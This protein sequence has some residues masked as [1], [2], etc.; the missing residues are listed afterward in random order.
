MSL[1]LIAT[2]LVSAALLLCVQFSYGQDQLIELEQA[3]NQLKKEHNVTFSYN[4]R[5][6]KGLKLRASL[7]YSDLTG[8][9]SKLSDL[10]PLRFEESDESNYLLIPIR[11]DL[12]FRVEDANDKSPLELIY[13][14][15]NQ[16][17]QTYLLSD[18]GLF[19][20]KNSFPT[21]SIEIGTSFY[22]SLTVRADEIKRDSPISLIPETTN[23]GEVTVLS[24]LTSGVNS[25]VSDHSMEINMKSLG[26]LAGD[27][28]GDILQILQAIP[29][30]R[31]P[32]GKPGTLNLRGS[33]FDQN[34]IYFDDIPIYHQG[35]FFGAFS[36]Y[37]PGVVE[38]ITVHR[39]ILPARFGGRVGGVFDIK[40][41]EEVPIEMNGGALANS[42][43]GGLEVKAPIIKNKLGLVFSARSN[44]P[45]GSLSPK[46]DS[47]FDLNFQGSRIGPAIDQ[48]VSFFEELD[49][50][51]SDIN[52]KLIF[53][54]DSKNQITASFL[55][56]KNDFSYQFERSQQGQGPN[57]TEIESEETELNNTGLNIQ[58]QSQLTDWLKARVSYTSSSL[59]IRESQFDID[60]GVTAVDRISFNTVEDTRITS[61]LAFDIS[62]KTKAQ[63]G[64]EYTDHAFTRD[65]RRNGPNNPGTEVVGFSGSI[66]AFYV[67]VEQRFGNRFISNFGLRSDQYSEGARQ[68]FDPR[69]TITYRADKNLFFKGGWG[70]SQQYVRQEFNEDFDDFRIDTQFWSV[71][72]R[73]DPIM[74]VSQIMVGT[75]YDK[76]SWLFDLEIY[77]K[78]VEHVPRSR[79]EQGF[80][81]GEL[82]TVGADILLKKRWQKLETWASYTLSH[83]LETF[84]RD[85]DAYNDQRHVL[86]LKM[87]YPANRWNF[88]ITWGY[89]S[90]MPVY[91]PDPDEIEDDSGQGNGP[92]IV[93]Y[94]GRFPAQHQLD[95]SATWLFTN[96]DA[97]WKGVL[98]LSILNLYDNENVINIFQ[99]NVQ[100]NR[101]TRFGLG[102]TPNIQIKISF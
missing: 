14:T 54:P 59:K 63:L 15:V 1:K 70:T 51:F 48:G 11:S 21:D 79:G 91:L 4:P 65:R 38:S 44:Y 36:P 94:S 22:Q 43:F 75:L 99:S 20:L 73:N 49:I 7:D 12:E 85:E 37:N 90:G 16:T 50:N 84:G 47:Y 45:T 74:N 17:A 72:N 88:A 71:T 97:R 87:L 80:D 53:Q 64:Y 58:W 24:Y 39:G 9:I 100:R 83:T 56:I 42:V 61:N 82:R 93:P 69:L 19:Q 52:S 101:P 92:L 41:I 5:L 29:G 60:Q 68:S 96:P 76:S 78:N 33:T 13:V 28:D 86:N 35:H 32:N 18:G 2:K 27:T 57:Q 77:A 95:L 67:S 3:L 66:N 26:P 55:N 46:L 89:M 8:S 62:D 23:L 102:F 10:L 31:S 25:K 6:V 30:I 98:G 40:T 34:V 81:F